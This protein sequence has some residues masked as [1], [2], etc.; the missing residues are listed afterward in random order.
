[1]PEGCLPIAGR[2]VKILGYA[3]VGFSRVAATARSLRHFSELAQFLAVFMVYSCGLMSV[4]A[5][6]AIYAERTIGFTS[7]D[8]IGLF[9]SM[10]VRCE[11]VADE[12]TPKTKGPMT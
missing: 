1:M 8:L 2:G 10:A 11:P 12:T 6:S 9:A 4:I 3:R 5:F 7:A